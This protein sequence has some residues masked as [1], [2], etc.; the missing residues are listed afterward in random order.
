MSENPDMSVSQRGF[1]VALKFNSRKSV[2]KLF[3]NLHIIFSNS[4]M[5]VKVVCQL[6]KEILK[7]RA[8]VQEVFS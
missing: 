3:H 6:K 4:L 2:Q 7:G 1:T 8:N 5:G